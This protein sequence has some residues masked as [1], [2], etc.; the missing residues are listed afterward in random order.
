MNFDLN[1]QA[2]QNKKRCWCGKFKN[3]NYP[4]CQQCYK[5]TNKR[6]GKCINHRSLDSMLE[7]EQ[8]DYCIK[9]DTDLE[10]AQCKLYGI[11][12][13]K[14]IISIIFKFINTYNENHQYYTHYIQ[15]RK[16]L[17]IE[18][19]WNNSWNYHLIETEKINK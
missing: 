16:N 8:Y 4:I 13:N 14:K 7:N 5:I 18:L 19:I 11:L 15:L 9:Y 17:I 6:C 12:T 10:R 2:N 3:V 1:I